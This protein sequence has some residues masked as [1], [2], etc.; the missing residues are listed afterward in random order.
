MWEVLV[1]G[2]VIT[3]GSFTII[4]NHSTLLEGVQIEES[5]T[6]MQSYTL[7]TPL[8]HETHSIESGGSS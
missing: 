5:I 3:A 8:T 1:D 4:D 7:N 2:D 6:P